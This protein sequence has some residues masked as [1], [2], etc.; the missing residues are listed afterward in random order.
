MNL[1]ACFMLLPA[2]SQLTPLVYKR[3][4]NEL[5]GRNYQLDLDPPPK[6]ISREKPDIYFT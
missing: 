1:I 3:L 5:S 6:Q 4:S 2:L